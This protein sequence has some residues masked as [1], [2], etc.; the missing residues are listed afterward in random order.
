MCDKMKGYNKIMEVLEKYLSCII[1]V[2][3][4]FEIFI[5]IVFR[6]IGL[7][8]GWTEETARYLMIAAV[9]FTMSRAMYERRHLSVG[10][11]PI[12]LKKEWNLK[13]F[14]G[15]MVVFLTSAVINPLFSHRGSTLLFYLFT[16]NPVTLESIVY[17]FATAGII[18]AMIMW[19]VSFNIIIT[20]DKI[21]AVLGKTMPVIATLLTMI[22]RFIP[23]MTE[24]GKDTLEAN[25]ALNGVKRQDEGKTIKAKIKNLKDK[26]KEEA[27][28]FS[29]ITTW[30]LENSVDTADSMRARGYGTGK[31][32][33]YNNYR[34]TVR[35]GIILLWSI[36]LTIATI[37]ALHN[38]IIITYY[39][40][41]IRI[42]ND[43]MAY[44]I[45]GLLCL[46]PVLINIW[47]TLRWNR[48]KSKI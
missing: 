9:F 5:Q 18:C 35:D 15:V 12:F 33:S 37:V 14:C 39:Y 6:E 42:K 26:F 46:T 47:E 30:S 4:T 22:L 17:G 36:V 25:Q 13:F 20:T 27:K 21:L 29:I 41:T 31:R 11:L 16:G 24:H 44:V 2:F 48:L 40:P 28:I 19:F 7:P 1:L 3:I 38:E 10:I 23:K 34:F 32:T 8:L 43:V 45:F